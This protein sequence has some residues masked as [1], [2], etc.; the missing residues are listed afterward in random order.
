MKRCQYRK[1]SKNNLWLQT[2]QEGKKMSLRHQ[3]FFQAEKASFS[4]ISFSLVS[5]IKWSFG[6]TS[7]IFRYQIIWNNTNTRNLQKTSFCFK[8]ISKAPK[9][10]S[11]NNVFLKLKMM[12]WKNIK[13][14]RLAKI[15]FLKKILYRVIIILK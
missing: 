10:Y 1:F 14:I 6:D 9:L 12:F 3:S 8:L 15:L 11:G 5:S 7:K 13:N 2:D 4:D